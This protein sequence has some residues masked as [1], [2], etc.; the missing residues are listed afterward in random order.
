VAV[1]SDSL[2][3]REPAPL[4]PFA[5]SCALDRGLVDLG[6][7]ERADPELLVGHLGRYPWSRRLRDALWRRVVR[8]G[9]YELVPALRT[10]ADAS[11][12]GLS[13][14]LLVHD[15]ERRFADGD[16]AGAAAQFE[17]AVADDPT[18][19][20]AWNDLGVALHALGRADAVDALGVGLDVGG[21]DG[22]DCIVNRAVILVQAGRLAEARRDAAA[23][24][25]GGREDDELRQV[26]AATGRA[27]EE[28]TFDA[29]MR[30]AA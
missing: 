10:A 3:T 20:Q 13:A 26:L 23:G 9:R 21:P 15:G 6:D 25:R 19:A 22:S 29:R 11:G 14:R 2:P 7:L 28:L 18:S 16:V 5:F 30:M 27:L 24:L 12:A 1:D 4:S 17:A 8:L